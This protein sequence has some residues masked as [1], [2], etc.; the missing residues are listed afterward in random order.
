MEP[1]VLFDTA[2][3]SCHHIRHVA[4]SDPKPH[5]TSKRVKSMKR[6]IVVAVAL[7]AIFAGPV[8]AIDYID[9]EMNGKLFK[10]PSPIVAD[11]YAN[12]RTDDAFP[13][14]WCNR[15]K[16]CL[17]QRDELFLEIFQQALQSPTILNKH[18]KRMP[19]DIIKKHA[20]PGDWVLP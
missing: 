4:P 18:I 14:N 8:F 15:S 10:I 17:N 19:K 2:A 1:P 12:K 6:F 16:K 7:M 11:D 3:D 20:I 13:R 9:V 5:R